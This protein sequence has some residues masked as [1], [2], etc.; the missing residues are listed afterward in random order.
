MKQI[1]TAIVALALCVPTV[2]SGAES[3]PEQRYKDYAKGASKPALVARYGA[4]DLRS[5]QLRL[6]KGK[7]PFPVAVVIHGG[8]WSADFDTVNGIAGVADALTKRGVATWNI[9]YRRLGNAG[10]GYPGTFEDVG[11][12]IDY[13]RVLA[14]RYPLDLRRVS[15][16]GHSSGAHLALWGASRG[17]LGMPY[18][19]KVKPVSVVAIDGPGSLAPFV[20]IDSQVC[21]RPVIVPLMGGKPDEKP[22]AYN[23]ASPAGHLP[24]GVH[25]LLILGAFTPF[26]KPYAAAAKSAGDNVD[27][28]QASDDHFDVV[29]PGTPNGDKVIDFI[30]ARAFSK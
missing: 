13:L 20:G 21:G 27:I 5:G 30:V 6:P 3:S 12:G 14:R 17:K 19:P 23:I 22:D 2:T 26:M 10:A 11:A 25:Q 1:F 8:C 9:E 18:V 15:I 24:L 7:G 28:L 29:T 4:D 16:I